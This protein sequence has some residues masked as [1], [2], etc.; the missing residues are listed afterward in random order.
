M[1][2]FRPSL[3][4]LGAGTEQERYRLYGVYPAL[5]T[6]VVD[7]DNQGR[8]EVEFP[9]TSEEDSSQAHAWARLATFMAGGERGS[10]FIPEVD[11]EVLVTFVAGDP[12][13]PVV[14]G[15]L[16]NGVDETPEAMD[17][18]GDNN[19]RSITSRSGHKLTF[20]DTSG[21]EKV[22]VV[23]QGG[24]ILNLDDGSGG[25]ITLRHSGGS[26]IKIDASG[27]ISITALNQVKVDA[28][29]GMNVTTSMLT[30][31]APLSKFSGV[32]KAETVITN[33]VVSSTYTPGAGNVW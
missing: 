12:R 32:V 7:P 10:W 1:T 2:S 9:W 11:D 19:I 29:A 23:T 31:D 8:V 17:T 26:E 27:T 30:V 20:D 25:E 16:W 5:V 4:G 21:A 6:D 22:E 24:H 28:P 18:A 3:A 14:I 33:A 13:W 15:S